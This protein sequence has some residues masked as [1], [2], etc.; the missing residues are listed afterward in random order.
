MAGQWPFFCGRKRL[1]SNF[2]Q[3]EVQ[4]SAKCRG[5]SIMIPKGTTVLHTYTT[6]GKG[7]HIFL[8][9]ECVLEIAIAGTNKFESLNDFGEYVVMKKLEGK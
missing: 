3:Y 5:C 2:N 1:M 8:C 9:D 7:M 6:V 4:Q